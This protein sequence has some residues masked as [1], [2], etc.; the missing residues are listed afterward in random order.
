MF[1]MASKRPLRSARQVYMF[2]LV[3]VLVVA[4]VLIVTQRFYAGDELRI[5][6]PPT[7]RSLILYL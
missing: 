1:V 7:Q 2:I 5:A 4:C 6:G 3:T